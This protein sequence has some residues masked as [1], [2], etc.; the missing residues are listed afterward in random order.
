[1]TRLSCGLLLIAAVATAAVTPAQRCQSKKNQIAGKYSECRQKAEGKLAVDGDGTAYAAALARCQ[2][3]YDD[4]WTKAEAAAVG[5][6]CQTTADQ[7]SIEGAVAA[8]TT[9][10]ASALAGGPLDDC[11]AALATCA[12]ERDACQ[13]D[14]CVIPGR[15]LVT[16]QTTCSDGAGTTIACAGTGQDGDVQA[17]LSRTFM[18][19]GDGT[20]T[21]QRTGLTWEKLSED[22]SIH[23]GGPYTWFEAITV[24]IAA[25]NTTPCFAGH[26]DW[27]LPNVIELQTLSDYGRNPPYPPAFLDNCFSGCDVLTCSCGVGR[28]TSTN[29]RPIAGYAFVVDDGKVAGSLKTLTWTVQA[30]RG[31]L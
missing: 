28:W 17:G 1:V 30:V 26:C 21:D 15:R 27:R 24:K 8:H 12:D 18:D 14:P 5:G 25:L 13:A 7:S 2:A 23:G 4:K 6:A 31:G 29:Y 3:T 20:I 11:D 19:N 22:G 9:N 16:G 10:V